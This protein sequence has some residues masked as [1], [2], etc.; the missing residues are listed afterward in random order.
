MSMKQ[1][2]LGDLKLC[3]DGGNTSSGDRALVPHKKK[4]QRGLDAKTGLLTGLLAGKQGWKCPVVLLATCSGSKSLKDILIDSDFRAY[5]V[6]NPLVTL[7]LTPSFRKDFFEGKNF[8]SHEVIGRASWAPKMGDG[9]V[10]HTPFADF[11][12]PVEE[13]E[14]TCLLK[15]INITRPEENPFFGSTSRHTRQDAM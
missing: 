13:L 5:P 2:L 15:T 8:F 14:Y 12:R 7:S 4:S 9:G 6:L 10:F 1:D 11:S 3:R